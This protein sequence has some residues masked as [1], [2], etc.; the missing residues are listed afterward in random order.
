MKFKVCIVTIT[1]AGN[2]CLDSYIAYKPLL[3]S[4]F[5]NIYSKHCEQS[6]E[7]VNNNCVLLK[8]PLNQDY[9]DSNLKKVDEAVKRFNQAKLR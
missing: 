4:S 5:E 6:F 3:F 9:Y 1:V 7:L 2:H 8:G